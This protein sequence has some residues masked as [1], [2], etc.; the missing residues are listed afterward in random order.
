MRRKGR[1]RRHVL[2]P[3]AC[4]AYRLLSVGEVICAELPINSLT[5]YVLSTSAAAAAAA[6]ARV[7]NSIPAT[8]RALIISEQLGVS[9]RD[10]VAQWTAVVLC[11]THDTSILTVDTD[12]TIPVSP[13]SR[14]TAVY[15]RTK[16]ITVRRRN[17]T[18]VSLVSPTPCSSFHYSNVQNIKVQRQ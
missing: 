3:A 8:H 7:D 1:R 6:A 14:Y 11:D 4:S 17:F 18:Q 12:V 13:R 5:G 10:P 15:R 2:S 9:A 16:L